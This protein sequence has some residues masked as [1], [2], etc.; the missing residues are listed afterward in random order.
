MREG[1]SENIPDFESLRMA[2]A[3]TLHHKYVQFS[4]GNRTL[5]IHSRIG[6]VSG[7]ESMQLLKG[8]TSCRW[9]YNY[10]PDA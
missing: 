8:S 9:Q 5:P 7:L 1:S 10:N 3:I 2:L 4:G 6:V